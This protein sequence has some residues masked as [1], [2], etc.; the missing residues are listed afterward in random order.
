[1]NRSRGAGRARWREKGMLMAKWRG[2]SPP[3]GREG[4]W[5]PAKR[6]AGDWSRAAPAGVLDP[7]NEA[8]WITAGV[9]HERYL[10][11]I[12]HYVLRRVPRQEEAED[13]TAEVFAAAFVA[14]PRFRGQ[15]SPY[16]WLLSIARH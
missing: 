3:G 15:C 12:L 16:L 1:M 4:P 14:L 5:I 11:D 8:D 2:V 9:L 13:I 10:K 6:M 7:M